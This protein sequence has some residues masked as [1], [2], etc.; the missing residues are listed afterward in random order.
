MPNSNTAPGFRVLILGGTGM[1]G[2]SF[3]K[4]LL[5]L[6]VCSC[7]RVADK[8]LPQISFM[9]PEQEALFDNEI[10]EF[11][12]ADL[13]KDTHLD[14]A[15]KHAADWDGERLIFDYVFNLAAETRYGQAV[16]LYES[17]CTELSKLCAQRAAQ[18]KCRRY[19]EVSTALVY[20]SQARTAAAEDYKLNP[21]TSQSTA[22]LAAEEE[23][24]K[25]AAAT[26]LNYIILR[27]A[28]IYGPAD[29]NGLMPR[30]VC[31]AAYVELKET[32]KFLW[33]AGIK[34]NTVHVSD[35]CAAMW[36]VAHTNRERV[37]SGEVFNLC[38]RGD[39]DVGTVNSFLS[40]LFGIKTGFHGTMLSNVARLRLADVVDIANDKHLKPWDTL[41][42]SNNIDRT[43]LSPFMSIELLDS[44]HLYV[45]GSKIER[46]TDFRYGVPTIQKQ[47]LEESIQAAIESQIFPPI[48]QK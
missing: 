28:I 18:I 38:D 19:V 35:V 27:P 37:P 45:N 6:G 4:Y 8:L 29:V 25:V 26:G 3:L 33:D 1:V 16:P 30:I 42:K 32:M 17:R 40:E 14:R 23:V 9:L 34:I 46:D 2:R 43:P 44:N 48:L 31:A 22:K 13:T 47:H 5:D 39:T 10:V 21:W 15:F 11:V 20:K 12:Q 36:T 41:C 7:I 24:K